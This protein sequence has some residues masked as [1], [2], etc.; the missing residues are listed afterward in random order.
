MRTYKEIVL[1]RYNAKV[2]RKEFPIIT[3]EDYDSAVLEF[4]KELQEEQI[5]NCA[6]S[7][8]ISYEYGK[9]IPEYKGTIG[10]PEPIVKGILTCKRVIE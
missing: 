4:A 2:A 5:K 8:F 9:T 10:P 3:W 1:E 7:A 6:E